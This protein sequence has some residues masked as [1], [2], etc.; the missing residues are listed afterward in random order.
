VAKICKPNQD[1]RFD[2]PATGIGTI[3]TMHESGARVLLIDAGNTVVFDKEKMVELADKHG[4]CIVARE[5]GS[6]YG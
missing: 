4:I 3:A 2:I 5:E 6:P 1:K